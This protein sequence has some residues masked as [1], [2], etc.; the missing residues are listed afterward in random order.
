MDVWKWLTILFQSTR[1]SETVVPRTVS[2]TTIETTIDLDWINLR[3]EVA[4]DGVYDLHNILRRRDRVDWCEWH[5]NIDE[6]DNAIKIA[7]QFHQDFEKLKSSASIINKNRY[8]RRNISKI[9]A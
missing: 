8:N 2:V 3:R 9:Y 6:N 4:S 1:R 7:K 5:L